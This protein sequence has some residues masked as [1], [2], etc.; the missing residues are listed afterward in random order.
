MESPSQRALGKFDDPLIEAVW[1]F[2]KTFM[3]LLFDTRKK[4][5]RTA[6]F[7]LNISSSP[8]ISACS[9]VWP[10]GSNRALFISRQTPMV[11]IWE[12][13]SYR[14][15][16]LSS[17]SRSSQTFSVFTRGNPNHSHPQNN[18]AFDS[19]L[20]NSQTSYLWHHVFNRSIHH[21]IS[22]T[23]FFVRTHSLQRIT[24]SSHEYNPNLGAVLL[25]LIL[26]WNSIRK[27]DNTTEDQKWCL[28]FAWRKKILFLLMW[29]AIPPKPRSHTPRG[30]KHPSSRT[31]V[32]LNRIDITSYRVRLWNNV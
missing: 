27:Y 1:R 12:T 28:C 15:T 24:F 4:Y 14:K 10:S 16:F 3:W 32:V 2:L 5:V 9:T 18:I 26:F 6:V 20:W 30:W 17:Y 8:K 21:K 31:P 11:L 22:G 7:F 13:L 29:L 19:A 23:F 25:L